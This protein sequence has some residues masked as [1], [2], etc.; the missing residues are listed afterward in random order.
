MS[1][2]AE[3]PLKN[4]HLVL[5][6]DGW[7]KVIRPRRRV[8]EL[9][10]RELW[11][12][13]DLIWTLASRDI[14]TS[15]KQTVLGPLWFILQPLLITAVFS[16]LFGRMARFGSDDIPHYLFYMGGLVPWTY[17]SESVMKTSNV[18]V[19]NALLFSKVYFPRL[20]VPVAS[21]LTNLVPTVVQFG[22]F[23]VGLITYLVQGDRFTHPNWF[24]L[25]TPLVFLQLGMFALGL[26][27][28]VSALSR[29]FRDLAFGVKIGLQL[30]MFGSAIVFPLSRV[31]PEE[32]W[33][34]F[35]NPVVP[36]IEFFRYA[37]VGKS[38]V[39]PWHIGLSAAVSVV[40][41]VTGLLLFHRAEQNAMDTV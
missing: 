28:I 18:F 27:C 14:A 6:A 37:F 22:L 8:F 10:F 25:L 5:D 15:Y 13:R 16:Y 17:F 3:A 36:P 24:I 38:L 1:A 35:L 21:L 2:P 19:D 9:P 31:A 33:I 23:G 30:L 32:R 39:E 4:P 29:R 12:Y 7:C 11:A 41:L 34:F 26:G 20:C 40:V